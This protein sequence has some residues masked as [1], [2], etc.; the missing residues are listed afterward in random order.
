MAGLQLC[1]EAVAIVLDVGPTMNS[2]P[3][4]EANPLNTAIEAITMILEDQMFAESKDEIALILFGTTSTDNPLVDGESYEHVSIA[5]PLGVADLDLLQMVQRDIHPGDTPADFIDA[6]IVAMDHLQSGLQGKR[7]FGVKRLIVLSD[8]SSPFGDDQL[9]TFIDVIQGLNVEVIF[10]GP[11]LNDD[12]DDAGGASPRAGG[13]GDATPGKEKTPQQR[14]GEAMAKYFIEKSNGASYSFKMALQS[15]QF[16]HTDWKCPQEVGPKAKDKHETSKGKPEDIHKT[17]KGKPE[18][19]HKTSK[20]KPEDIH[21]TSKGKPEDIHKTSKGKPEDIHKTSKGKPVAKQMTLKGKGKDKH[22]LQDASLSTSNGKANSITNPQAAGSS[23]SAETSRAAVNRN[24]ATERSN[25]TTPYGHS[26][27]TPSHQPAANP[28]S[29]HDTTSH[30]HSL[31]APSHQPAANPD[32][33]H[34]TT[35]H[36]HSLSAPSHQPAANPDSQHDVGQIAFTKYSATCSAVLK[37]DHVKLPVSINLEGHYDRCS[38]TLRRSGDEMELLEITMARILSDPK[39]SSG[40]IKDCLSELALADHSTSGTPGM[41]GTCRRSGDMMELLEI[42][43]ARIQSD[44]N[45]LSG[46]IKDYLS[47]LKAWG[48][49]NDLTKQR[50][51]ERPLVAVAEMSQIEDST[52]EGSGMEG[53][54]QGTLGSDS[55]PPLPCSSTASPSCR[56]SPSQREAASSQQSQSGL[57][58]STGPLHEDQTKGPVCESAAAEHVACRRSTRASREVVTSSGDTETL[59]HQGASSSSRITRSTQSKLEVNA[60]SKSPQRELERKDKTVCSDQPP[61]TS[62]HQQFPASVCPSGASATDVQPLPTTPGRSLHSSTPG[63]LQLSTSPCCLQSPTASNIQQLAPTTGL[64]HLPSCHQHSM[65]PPCSQQLCSTLLP[66]LLHS[67]H[68]QCR[69]APCCQ[70][71]SSNPGCHLSSSS[72]QQFTPTPHCE[73][74]SAHSTC[75]LHLSSHHYFLSP[76]CNAELHSRIACPHSQCVQACTPRHCCQ[77]AQAP[78]CEGLTQNRMGTNT[79][80]IEGQEVGQEKATASTDA[81]S[82]EDAETQEVHTTRHEPAEEL[83]KDQQAVIERWE[84][85][86]M[87]VNAGPG[88]GKTF[89]LCKLIER[90]RQE[91]PET[92]VLVLAYNRYAVSELRSCLMNYRV[93]LLEDNDTAYRSTEEGCL[94]ATFHSFAQQSSDSVRDFKKGKNEFDTILKEN[95]ELLK[96]KARDSPARTWDWVIVDEGQD[97]TPDLA[98]LVDTLRLSCRHFVVAGDPRQAI[99]EGAT[100]FSDLL[101]S[102]DM[103]P[104]KAKLKYNHR[105]GPEL[106]EFLNDYSRK[107]FETYD[108]HYDQIPLRKNQ[109]T[110]EIMATKNKSN[111]GETVGRRLLKSP[112]DKAYAITPASLEKWTN[113]QATQSIAKTLSDQGSKL[114]KIENLND[115]R[116]PATDVYTVGT[117]CSLKGT[118]RSRVVVYGVSISFQPTIQDELLHRMIFVA[119]SRARDHLHIILD[120]KLPDKSPLKPFEEKK[121]ETRPQKYSKLKVT[122]LAGE[123][124]RWWVVKEP[125]SRPCLDQD[126]APKQGVN[127][128]LHGDPGFVGLYVESVIAYVLGCNISDAKVND[129]L[130]QVSNLNDE[131]KGLKKNKPKGEFIS[132]LQKNFLDVQKVNPCFAFAQARRSL[133][134]RKIYEDKDQI[135]GQWERHQ[136]VCHSFTDFLHNHIQCPQYQEYLCLAITPDRSSKEVGHLVGIADFVGKTSVV[137]IKHVSEIRREH[138]VQT[139]MYA[140]MSPQ[141][142][143]ALLVNLKDADIKTVTAVNPVELVHLARAK[144]A[145]KNSPSHTR[146]KESFVAVSTVRNE[147]NQVGEIGAVAFSLAGEIMGTYHRIM[148]GVEE[149]SEGRR[150]PRD[151]RF[152]LVFK[153]ARLLVGNEDILQKQQVKVTEDF[154]RWF[155]FMRGSGVQCNLVFWDKEDAKILKLRELSHNSIHLPSLLSSRDSELSLSGCVEKLLGD[156]WPYEAHRAFEDAVAVAAL[157][158]LL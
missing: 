74:C 128:G 129:L 82:T 11:D 36:G 110:V 30:G 72:H 2:A 58:S 76:P 157:K 70:Q 31:S 92:R 93:L 8:L 46:H 137:E 24:S 64:Q 32:S 99:R 113:G 22:K 49:K 105:S 7:G 65:S 20:G 155:R 96:R 40:H 123:N 66:H 5:R 87:I 98:E 147:S 106:V 90:V 33:Q 116:V 127:I 136:E 83:D 139:A 145:L 142:K 37:G 25:D 148:P 44:P 152:S 104:Y 28:D 75:H 117:V 50:T 153:K 103:E 21:K 114:Q 115:G 54:L 120:K 62:E 140:A 56:I 23:R 86:R 14:A 135:A 134:D 16:R 146:K 73:Q 85:K 77:Q 89:T 12:D 68:P 34:D 47:E 52:S 60:A 39:T 133:L 10:I 80:E 141:C 126:R 122:D 125:L 55:A 150:L 78:L 69:S 43:M 107:T 156:D 67:S 45:K 41:E 130:S 138:C 154:Q 88:S 19:I 48:T 95:V 9:E 81:S 53:T 131:V 94:V 91:R 121:T 144:L 100:W 97:V 118:E 101:R 26:L 61:S 51:A 6:M 27:S 1:E 151:S 79:R 4:G 29:R 102:P 119:I 149:A 84:D 38:K 42:T 13:S 109:A 112:P 59:L 108:L 35:S 143:E 17:S 124:Y 57:L 18:D 71:L 15:L 63:H 158:L 3:E 132:Q 111:M